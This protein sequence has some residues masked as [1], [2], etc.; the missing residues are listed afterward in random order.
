[1]V[2]GALVDA[3]TGNLARP[4]DLVE[5]IMGDDRVQ[6]VLSTRT[7]GLL[8][9]P[10][11]FPGGSRAA[12]KA[13]EGKKGLEGQTAVPG[14][15]YTMFPEAQVSQLAAWGI[16]LGVGLG[17]RVPN[18]RDLEEREVPELRIW[19][20]RWLRQDVMTERWYLMTSGGEIEITPGDGRWIMYLP[21]GQTRPWTMGAWRPLSFAWVL[22]QFALHDRA[23]HSE[24]QG[25]A[26]RVG[27]APAGATA[28]GR[29]Q[30]LRDIRSMGRDN[31]IVLPFGYDYK[32]VEAT[33]RT[34]EIY[35]AQIEWADRAIAITLAG[36]AVTTEGT[37]GF[38]NGNIHAAI[39][40]DLITFTAETL[41]TTLRAQGV[42]PWAITNFGD[43]T[44]AP[45]PRWDTNP[46]LDKKAMAEAIA[47]LGD[48]I[49]KCDA[50]LASIGKRVDAIE[51]ASQFGI[52]LLDAPKATP[53]NETPAEDAQDTGPE[54]PAEDQQDEA[55]A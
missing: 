15:W 51:L 14:D 26:A 55:A 47:T 44:D 11:S 43:E 40:K 25:S 46:P 30:W 17:E 24:V 4:A 10:L 35:A 31:S 50:A 20:P 29:K 13:L 27:I 38:S 2:K 6:G 16:V 52:P 23:R 22:K 49:A 21:Y 5:A 19:N 3:D 36:Q 18:K 9:L 28:A 7:H 34:Y 1:M 8:G 48:A 42:V 53:A 37:S 54:T 33:G 39:K 41:S 12:Q 32:I 45:W